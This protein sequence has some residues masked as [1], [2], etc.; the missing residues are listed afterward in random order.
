MTA[1]TI[2]ELLRLAAAQYGARLA[3]RQPAGKG[4][5]L[6]WTWSQYLEAAEEIAAGLRALGL[7]KAITSRCVRKRARNFI[8]PIRAC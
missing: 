8:W 4:D 1:Q 7:G 5:A 3:L 6:T 2:P